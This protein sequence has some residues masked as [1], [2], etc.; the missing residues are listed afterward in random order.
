[1]CAE[2]QLECPKQWELPQCS[3]AVDTA[4]ERVL[5]SNGDLQEYSWISQTCREGARRSI[6]YKVRLCARKGQKQAELRELV[7]VRMAGG[8]PLGSDGRKHRDASGTGSLSVSWAQGWWCRCESWWHDFLYVNYFPV[9]SLK[10]G[11]GWLEIDLF[12]FR[13]LSSFWARKGFFQKNPYHLTHDQQWEEMDVSNM[14]QEKLR[15]LRGSFAHKMGTCR[16]R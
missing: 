6:V 11:K 9:R 2:K 4:Q 5:C 16:N 14:S 15:S 1:M 10:I 13:G 7:A 8:L 12:S 3:S